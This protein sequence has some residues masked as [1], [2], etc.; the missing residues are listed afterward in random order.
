MV[1]LFREV[2][3]QILVEKEDIQYMEELFWIKILQEH[4]LV[5][6]YYQWPI[7]EEIQTLLNFL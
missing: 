7:A 5:Q 6:D 2:I 3:Y 4:T 1:L